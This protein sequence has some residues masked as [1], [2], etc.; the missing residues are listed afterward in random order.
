[1]DER[2]RN[3][4]RARRVRRG[5][6]VGSAGIATEHL[7]NEAPYIQTVSLDAIVRIEK[8]LSCVV[9]DLHALSKKLRASLEQ[10]DGWLEFWL[11]VVEGVAA[12]APVGT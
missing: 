5:T 9:P 10:I 2:P 7:D 12:K 3:G 4:E 1:M 11:V 6:A 8:V